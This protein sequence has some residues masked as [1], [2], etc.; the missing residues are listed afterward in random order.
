MI[1]LLH[2]KIIRLCF[3][4]DM[5]VPRVILVLVHALGKHQNVVLPD[6]SSLLVLE[7]IK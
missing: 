4:E 1:Y 6:F 7:N 5:R 3:A 2:F